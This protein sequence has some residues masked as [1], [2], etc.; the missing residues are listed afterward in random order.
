MLQAG[1]IIGI[2][3]VAVGVILI[4]VLIWRSVVYGKRK[5]ESK[6]PTE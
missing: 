5:R 3:M 6:R 1:P 2:T 4:A